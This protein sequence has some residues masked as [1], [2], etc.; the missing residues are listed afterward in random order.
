MSVGTKVAVIGGG[1]AGLYAAR[2]LH[3][4]SGVDF[5][6]LEARDRLGGRVQ[7]TDAAG[8]PSADGFDLGASWFWPDMQPSLGALVDELG[9]AVMPQNSEGAVIIHRMSREAPQLYQRVA[10]AQESQSMRLVGGTGTLVTALAQDLPAD[11]LQ[12]KARVTHMTLGEGNVTLT[13]GGADGSPQTLTAEHV[14]AALPPRLL[15]ATVSFTP[16]MDP[17]TAQ[18][19]RGTPTW[20]APHA[21]FF[22]FY[23]RPFWRE[24]GL[25]GTAQS[26]V[27]PL[28]EIHDATTASGAAA[29]LGFLGVGADQRAS[30]G[31]EALTQACV[32]QLCR[33]FGDEARRPRATLIK[34]WATDGLTSTASDRSGGGHPTP[35]DGSWVTG[36][37]QERLVLGGSETSAT[38]PGYL[39]GAI[40][41]ARRAVAETLERL[42]SSRGLH[43]IDS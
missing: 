38:D 18:R 14:I 29:L 10:S 23:E 39:A 24:A 41:A 31:E 16:G 20:M 11:R 3:D 30:I 37:W 19:W 26:L 6:L 25:S 8:R 42:G 9:L 33:L 35:N 27:G 17:A 40:E 28:V 4:A 13:I 1:L 15:E 22:A 7:T 43:R 36:P 32:E 5:R 2:L 12:L 21:K 34:D